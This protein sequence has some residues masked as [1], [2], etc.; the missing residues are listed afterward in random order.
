MNLTTTATSKGQVTIPKEIRDKLG[1]RQ[2]TKIDIALTEN[3]FIG[4]VRGE[5]RILKYAG[6]LKHLDDGKPLAEIR[7]RAQA[8]AAQEIL[9]QAGL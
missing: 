6:D 5:S 3:G 4:R 1:L 9:D 8:L 2:G 7:A